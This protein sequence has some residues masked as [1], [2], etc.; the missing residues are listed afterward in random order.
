MPAIFA[1][2]PEARLFW[3]DELGQFETNG[4]TPDWL[5][6][7]QRTAGRRKARETAAG[8]R[9]ERGPDAPPLRTLTYNAE[10]PQEF[11]ALY[12]RVAVRADGAIRFASTS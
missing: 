3:L 8:W 4:D 10:H 6:G 5:A 7:F 12:P 1:G 9:S 11:Q 2:T